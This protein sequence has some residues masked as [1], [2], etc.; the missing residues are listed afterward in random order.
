MKF[1]KHTVLALCL[2]LQGFAAFAQK[3]DITLEDIFVK[4]TFGVRGGGG[5]NVM[6]NGEEYTELSVK[7][8]QWSIDKYGL[9]SGNKTATV[10]S[11][12]DLKTN[13]MPE[14]Y[15]FS[16][17]E[18]YI[19]VMAESEQ[20]YRHS[21]R[22]YAY[23]IDIA[24]KQIMSIST[25]KVMY[26]TL[27]PDNSSVAFVKD[28]NLYVYKLK[29]KKLIAIT[30]DGA[31]NKVINGAV[32]WV[33]EEEFSM[34]QGF[35]WSAD[36]SYLAYYRFDESAV[37][38]FSMDIF[39][40]LYP[41][42]EQWKYP[43]AGEDNSKV[44]VFIYDTKKGK[45]VKCATDLEADQ[46][47]PRIKWTSEA[48]KL[49]IQRL[50]RTQNHWDLLFADA[51]TGKTTLVLTETSETYVDIND[52]LSFI[53]GK[54]QFIYTSEKSG[55]NSIYLYDYELKKSTAIVEEKYD[56]IAVC[57]VDLAGNKV[58]YTS[59]EQGPTEDKLYCINMDGTQ[60]KLITHESGN[61]IINFMN[62]G[63]YFVDL[64]S[65]LNNPYVVKL[66]AA[67]GGWERTLEDNKG[68]REKM[69]N[70]NFGE[71]TFSS[72]KTE[73]GVLLNYWMM[74]PHNF[75]PNKKY[76]VL[77]HVYGGPGHNTVRNT[78]SGRNFL[79]HQMLTQKGYIVISVDNRGTGNRG[80]AFKKSTY[81]NLGK[82]E[83]RDQEQAAKWLASQSFVDPARIGIWGWSFGGYMTSLCMTKSSEVFKMG[84]A[85]APVT[86]WRYYDN[87]YTE[88]FLRRP[89]ENAVGYDTN[90]PINFV[91]NIK[92]N[93][94]IVHG[95][96]DDN[97]HFQ[98][99]VEMVDA[100]IKAGVK[101]DSEIYP[102]R[103]HGIG[104]PK[105]IYH[106]YNRMTDYILKNL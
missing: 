82:L 84:I 64:Y 90:S 52:N 11:G 51:K 53:P 37:K 70:Y 42:Q 40:G 49:S 75:D 105:A 56:V 106:L 103:N 74:K 3:S 14:G 92:G 24:A 27:S 39:S 76:P 12:T 104:D 26:P 6:Q 94:L 13:V 23:V 43:K 101:F 25:E 72:F 65:S 7:E 34:S 58:Y 57:N 78:W 86:N 77:M 44:N 79:W 61:H 67:D 16:N 38:E 80:A 55:Y 93:Y 10:I 81:L 2:L 62:G 50:N 102:N 47:V 69:N 18:K 45:S 73:D 91:K 88:R 9:K 97:V 96:A 87:I 66:I 48:G 85:V 32:D 5:F 35:Q 41:A 36:G 17:D 54:K 31:R 15:Q 99:T 29:T 89:S 30:K 98:N 60:K 19:L 28:N 8:G 59:A 83:H 63:K 100:M 21:E 68:V 20:I 71:V 22:G 46:Y 95:T 4:R 1:F 33:Y